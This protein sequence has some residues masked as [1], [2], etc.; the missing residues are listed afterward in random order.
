LIF[1]KKKQRKNKKKKNKVIK[2]STQK[3]YRIKR[4]EKFTKMSEDHTTN[5]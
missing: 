5:K 3:K 4:E 1:R 2:I